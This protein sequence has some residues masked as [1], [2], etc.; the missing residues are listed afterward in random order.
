[1]HGHR[2]SHR[3]SLEAV[4]FW[5]AWILVILWLAFGLGIDVLAKRAE[6]RS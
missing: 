6:S 2:N 3:P 1:V 5:A 4:W